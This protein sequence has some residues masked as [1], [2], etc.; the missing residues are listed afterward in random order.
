MAEDGAEVPRELTGETAPGV[1]RVCARGR[2]RAAHAGRV[3]QSGARVGL[4]P[5]G[6]R[7]AGKFAPV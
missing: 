2:R 6:S 7:G 1:P 3:P 4:R 5:G